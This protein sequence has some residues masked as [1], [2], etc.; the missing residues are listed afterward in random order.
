MS[1]EDSSRMEKRKMGNNWFEHKVGWPE[2][3]K[4]I[5]DE[6]MTAGK[7]R[8]DEPGMEIKYRNKEKKYGKIY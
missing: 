7:R 3:T 8:F 6:R 5:Y 4:G 1:F 2:V